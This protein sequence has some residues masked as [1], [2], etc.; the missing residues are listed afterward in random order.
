LQ[1]RLLKCIDFGLCLPAPRTRRKPAD[2]CEIGAAEWIVLRQGKRLPNLGPRRIEW[3]R[4]EAA[5]RREAK[6]GRQHSDDL[7]RLPIESDG[8]A[9]D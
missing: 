5:H 4:V 9:D 1:E 8:P 7:V 6:V 3:N 2:G